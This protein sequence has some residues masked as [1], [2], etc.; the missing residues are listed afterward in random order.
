MP[1]GV[2]SLSAWSQGC[3]LRGGG[4]GDPTRS[5]GGPCVCS[6]GALEGTVSTWCRLGY[7]PSSCDLKQSLWV[8]GSRDCSSLTELRWWK[9]V[10]GL[11]CCFSVFSS[12]SPSLCLG[13]GW[14]GWPDEG[15]CPEVLLDRCFWFLCL[16]RQET[17]LARIPFEP[18]NKNHL[19]KHCM[20][21]TCSSC[22]VAYEWAPQN[23]KVQSCL[24]L[25]HRSRWSRL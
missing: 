17:G 19:W 22:N 3:G 15:G 25:P 1:P 16:R 8:C 14:E 18:V 5:A 12:F 21:R 23:P 7:E 11:F 20:Q 24:V 10:C 6:V 13:G 2:R 4:G 9:G